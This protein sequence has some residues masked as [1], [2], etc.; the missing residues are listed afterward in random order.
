M[1]KYP[2]WF[3]PTPYCS[4]TTTYG[5]N[6]KKHL[7]KVHGWE[8]ESAERTVDRFFEAYRSGK[9][10]VN[11]KSQWDPTNPVNWGTSVS[12]RSVDRRSVV[13]SGGGGRG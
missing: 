13:V 3:C 8:E 7:T 5:N 12:R 11:N 1:A 9:D 4:Y 2:R 6:I 10:L